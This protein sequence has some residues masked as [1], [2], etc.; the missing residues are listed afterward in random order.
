M[1]K[2]SDIQ[3]IL[4]LGAGPIVIGQACEFDYS[5]TQ[6]CV[7]LREEGYR[8]ILINSNPATIMTDPEMADATYIEPITPKV[9]EAIIAKEKPDAVLPTMGGQTALN[10]AMDL[11]ANG[12]LAKHGVVLIGAQPEVIACAEDR[13]LFRKAMVDIGLAMARSAVATTMAQAWEAATE[14]GYPM[15]VRPSFTLGG[16]GGGIAYNCEEFEAICTRGFAASPTQSLLID[17]CLLG[18][19]EFEL[20]VVRDAADN[21]MVV[22]SIENVDPMGVHTGDS[23]TVAPAQTLTDREYQAMRSAALAVLRRVGV[24]T[25]GANVQFAVDPAT[26]RMVVIEMNPR[27]SRSSAL[28][29]KATGFPIAKVA[30]KLAVGYTL[31]ELSADVIGA[32]IPASFEPTLDYVVVKIPRFNFDKFKGASPLLGT[33]MKSVGEVMALGSTFNMALQKAMRSLEL[34]DIA[35][36][37]RACSKSVL[38]KALGQPRWDRLWYVFEAL[39]QA[40]PLATM[41][42]RTGIDEWF[43]QQLCDWVRTEQH[44]QA[45]PMASL[46]EADW[47]L[48]KS[49]GFSDATMAQWWSIDASVVMAARLALGVKAVYKRVDSCAAEFPCATQFYYATYDRVTEVKSSGKQKVVILGSG[50]NRI[51]QGVEFD[52][53]CVHAAMALRAMGIEA[54]MVNCNPET[55]STDPSVSDRLYFEPLTLEDV[56]AVIAAE[57]PLGVIVHFGGQTPLKLTRQLHDQGVKILGTSA[58]AIS[59]AED[60]QAFAACLAHLGLTQPAQSTLVSREMGMFTAQQHDYPVL[61]RPSFVLGGQDMAVLHSPQDLIAY[62]ASDVTVSADAP[63]LI[64]RFLD[65]AVEIDVDCLSDGSAVIVAGVMEHIEEAGVHSGDSACCMPAQQLSADCHAEI[66]RQSKAL[67]KHLGVVGLMNIQFAVKD[68][69]IYILEVN[70]RA[71]RTVPFLSKVVNVPLAK[72][73]TQLKLGR[74][75][76]DLGLHEDLQAA[77]HAIKQPVFPFDRFPEVDPMLGPQMYSTGEVMGVGDAFAQAYAQAQLGVGRPLPT[78]GRVLITVCDD[79]KA[80]IVPIARAFIRLGFALLGTAGTAGHLKAKGLACEVVHKVAEGRPHVVD[81][82][83]NAEVDL[84]VNTVLGQQ[85]HEDS[86]HVRQVVVQ[87]RVCYTTTISGAM[88]MVEAIDSGQKITPES[89]Q[90]RYRKAHNALLIQPTER[91]AHDT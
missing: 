17:E 21:A 81:L 74:R 19:K 20:E 23:I 34:P 50:P 60:R 40:V 41:I 76:A 75:L 30:A 53:C 1:P 18:W 86:K 91:A 43:L 38:L 78:S 24:T 65:H 5:G 27:V 66:V 77:F 26:G 56:S 35:A 70:P 25:G 11:A 61:A 47:R 68:G 67:A 62:L 69:V 48:L 6:A 4:I 57:A 3:S 32:K 12:V 9:V 73:A 84:V 22:C 90:R 10:C 15:V 7:A 82:I 33:Q 36:T 42:Q 45:K 79:D 28:A 51:G 72:V 39:R 59:E 2:R 83:K 71:S 63:L 55:V 49:Q 89:L 88:A 29:S 37:L 44:F 58:H 87:A 64:D 31:P 80:A 14:L 54:V 16:A 13:A 52:Y 8:V 46:S 85:A